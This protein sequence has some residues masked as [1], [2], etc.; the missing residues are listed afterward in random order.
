MTTSPVKDAGRILAERLGLTVVGTEGHDLKCKCVACDSTDGMRVHVEKGIAQCYACKSSWS[1]YD[2]AVKLLG[3]KG[4]AVELMIALGIFE[5]RGNG[6]AANGHYTAPA[7]D[8]LEALARQKNVHPEALKAFGA[9]VERGAVVVPMY[10]PDGALC[11]TFTMRPGGDKGKNARGKP[12]GVFLPEGRKPQPGE[13]WLVVE[14]CKDAA[15]AWDLGFNALGTSGCDLRKDL[16]GL[17]AGC[18]VIIVPDLDTAGQSG[19]QKTA[20]RLYGQ[21]SSIRIARLPGEV[22]AKGGE[23]LRDVL[24]R[25]KGRDLVINAIDEAKAWRP[26]DDGEVADSAGDSILRPEARTDSANA[27]RLAREHGDVIRYCDPWSTFLVFEGRRW[28]IDNTRKVEALAKAVAQHVW[29]EA[30]ELLPKVESAKLANELLAFAKTTSNAKGIRDMLALVRSEPG[31]AILPDQLDQD[32]W[33]L[34]VQNGTVDLRTQKLRSHRREDYITRL[35]PVEFQAGADCPLWCKFLRDI[36]GDNQ[37]LIDFLRRMV[38]FSLTGT[39]L[40]HVLLF[41]YGTGAN[42]KSTFIN[43]LLALFGDYAMQAPP[44]LL[45]AKKHEAHPTE[46]AD[47]YGKRFVACVETEDDRRFA[48]SLVKSLTGGD[49][50]RARRCREDFW[51]FTA[52]HKVWVAGNYKPGVRGTDYGMWRRIKLV[53]FT[54]TIP[55]AQQDRGLPAKLLGELPGILNWAL[56]GC[57]E[58]QA[59][60]LGEPE[61]VRDATAEYRS[62]MDVVGQFLDEC[63]MVDATTRAR[64]AAIYAAYRKWADETGE[65]VISQKRFGTRLTDRGFQREASNG[66]WYRGVGLAID[67]NAS[68][69]DANG[70][71]F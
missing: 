39:T 18:H 59:G 65:R 71:L 43:T 35:C 30:G 34:N 49:K 6:H 25:P 40:D 41:L 70:G 3:A 55:D 57:K 20:R 12:S 46:R 10:G 66:V 56:L 14:G 15:A 62:E 33:L 2:L 26:M 32:P 64:A 22:V 37:R 45:M 24:K 4:A 17:L 27:K 16:A 69:G 60:G 13:T 21:V 36:T 5:D 50:I 68:N 53:P 54:V 28:A 23:D 11:S 19:A 52:T 38:G 58:W 67:Q 9:T 61:E 48:E 31:I 42:G 7:V 63:C 47:L 51:E 1:A 8:P 29:T 44:E